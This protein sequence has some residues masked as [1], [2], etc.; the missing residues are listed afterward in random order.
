MLS[1]LSPADGVGES[2]LA[3]AFAARRAAQRARQ[4]ERD[5]VGARRAGPAFG[6]KDLRAA[7]TVAG[8]TE[9]FVVGGRARLDAYRLAGDWDMAG[10]ATGCRKF[11][12]ADVS[13]AKPS[14]AAGKLLL[15]GSVQ[16]RQQDSNW[17]YQGQKQ[18][19]SQSRHDEMT[20]PS[21]LTVA[22]TPVPLWQTN[23]GGGHQ[24]GS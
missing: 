2:A 9:V 24:P 22:Y 14:F 7:G 23:S 16:G 5:A 8:V 4:I 19:D 11:G 10:V 18:A 1:R 12:V 6:V 15:R 17:H 21:L 13:R 3:G 20:R